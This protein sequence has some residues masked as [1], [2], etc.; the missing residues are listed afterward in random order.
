MVVT[1]EETYQKESKIVC[2]SKYL[3]T[4][5]EAAS[6]DHYIAKEILDKIM[7]FNDLLE[8]S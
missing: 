2:G 5:L 8:A 7:L 3:L 4:V 6:R 1:V